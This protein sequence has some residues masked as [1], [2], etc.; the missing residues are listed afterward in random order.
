MVQ[1]NDAALNVEKRPQQT[2]VHHTP[3]LRLPLPRAH[4]LNYL[5]GLDVP[6]VAVGGR[7]ARVAEL[8]LD[9]VHGHALARQLRSVRVSQAVGVDPL[10]D[11][12]FAGQAR[13]QNAN[14]GR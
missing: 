9:H 13:Q 2:P 4:R 5:A 7:Q 1:T 8:G 12:C 11:P 3:P 10:L 14:V 6:D